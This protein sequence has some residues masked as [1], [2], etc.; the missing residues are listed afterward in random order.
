[1]KGSVSF[2]VLTAP[3]RMGPSATGAAPLTGAHTLDRAALEDPGMRLAT[4]KDQAIPRGF[5]HINCCIQ[6]MNAYRY[7]NPF[8]DFVRNDA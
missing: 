3:N 4:V 7:N 5:T 1:M 6:A 8:H 2:Q